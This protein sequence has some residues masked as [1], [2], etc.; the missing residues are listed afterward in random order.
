MAAMADEAKRTQR[1]AWQRAMLSKTMGLSGHV[2]S[3]VAKPNLDFCM[4]QKNS[5]TK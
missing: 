2:L 4:I 1:P 3:D 5:S